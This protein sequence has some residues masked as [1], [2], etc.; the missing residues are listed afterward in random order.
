[1]AVAPHCF[2]RRS[3]LIASAI[4]PRLSTETLE[5]CECRV[6]LLASLGPA[7]SPSQA[8]PKAKL[9]TCPLKR[10]VGASVQHYRLLERGLKVVLKQ[11]AGSSNGG[12]SPQSGSSRRLLLQ[13]DERRL[14][15]R[16]LPGVDIRFDQI[17]AFLK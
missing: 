2:S 17:R 16:A 7:A 8:L 10:H 3:Q 15:L 1:L 11:P 13:D 12:T 14:S 6:Q 5:R 4:G 9:S